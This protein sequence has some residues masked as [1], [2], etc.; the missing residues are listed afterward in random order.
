MLPVRLRSTTTPRRR[1]RRRRLLLGAALAG[2]LCWTGI[3]Y[4]SSSG[5]SAPGVSVLPGAAADGSVADVVPLDSAGTVSSG[6]SKKLEGVKI[7]RIDL[8]LAVQNQVRVSLAWQ[9][10]TAI[11]VATSTGGW[12]LRFGL[13]F[14]V[15]TGACGG[16]APSHA[17]TVTIAADES[18]NGSE[19]TLCAYRDDLATGVGVVTAAGDHR[20]T[21]LLATNYLVGALQPQNTVSS[22]AAC[23]TTGTVACSPAGLGPNRRTYLLI[24][25]MLNP[26]GNIPPGQVGS[27][28]GIDLYVKVSKVG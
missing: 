19:Q 12:Q 10:P 2:V 17:V 9:N 25:S 22:P 11:S 1:A 7:A 27:A 3:S 23:T 13:Y 14:P 6:G 16:G 5:S 28:T 15:H 21:Q 4:L 18:W 26:A 20:G 24:A 8:A